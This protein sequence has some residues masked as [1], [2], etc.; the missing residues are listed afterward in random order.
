[1]T[2]RKDCAQRRR[3]KGGAMLEVLI[4]IFVFSI[5]MLGIIAA[6]AQGG[7]IVFDAQLRTQAAAAADELLSRIALADPATRVAQFS[8]GG[9]GFT[10]WVDERLTGATDTLP[11]AQAVVTFGVQAGDPR[12]VRVEI[13]WRPPRDY[14]RYGTDRVRRIAPEHRHVTVSA[15]YD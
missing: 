3:E 9:A 13:S 14:E 10:A 4:A 1:M 7:R 12:T 15:I 5:G 8:T 11:G 2:N 6:Q